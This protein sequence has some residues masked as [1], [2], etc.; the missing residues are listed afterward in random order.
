MKTYAL[1]MKLTPDI[2]IK[3][4]VDSDEVIDTIKTK[5]FMGGFDFTEVAKYLKAYDNFDI[6]AM[7]PTHSHSRVIMVFSKQ[8][9]TVKDTAIMFIQ[10]LT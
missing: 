9:R 3:S 6:H 4:E 8:T 7:A 1:Q 5:M 2:M 10:R